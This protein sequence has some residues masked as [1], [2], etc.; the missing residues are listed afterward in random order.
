MQKTRRRH[1]NPNLHHWP[2]KVYSLQHHE[3]EERRHLGMLLGQAYCCRSN[4]VLKAAHWQLEYTTCLAPNLNCFIWL[5]VSLLIFTTTTHY[6][7]TEIVVMCPQ[8][9]VLQKVINR[10]RLCKSWRW[11]HHAIENPSLNW[12]VEQRWAE[13]W[14]NF[15]SPILDHFCPLFVQIAQMGLILRVSFCPEYHHQPLFFAQPS[16][17]SFRLCSAVTNF[18]QEYVCT[19]TT[20]NPIQN[21]HFPGL[22]LKMGKMNYH[23]GKKDPSWAKCLKSGQ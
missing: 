4:T 6:Y 21:T 12:S 5:F 17:T 19:Q 2:A 10:P 11:R 8:W 20:P 23:L 22:N 14:W 7:P 13:T 15:L 3:A 16:Q 9:T 18:F 1:H